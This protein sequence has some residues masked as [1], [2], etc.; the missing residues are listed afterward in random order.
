MRADVGVV[1]RGPG[2]ARSAQAGGMGPDGFT[3]EVLLMKPSGAFLGID[4][5]PA[6]DMP[7]LIVKQILKGG[8]V[9]AW[10]N[11]CKGNAFAVQAGDHIV[12]VNG[13]FND[14]TALMEEMRACSELRITIMRKPDALADMAGGKK[15]WGR[16]GKTGA[17]TSG[18]KSSARPSFKAG[19]CATSCFPAQTWE[20]PDPVSLPGQSRSMGYKGAR[21]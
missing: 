5:L 20:A 11:Q 8:A 12:Q 10:N 3:F 1:Q 7:C 9:S 21:P 15:G 17:N 14:I 18:A 16:A 6:P 2:M 19:E 4:T 13:V